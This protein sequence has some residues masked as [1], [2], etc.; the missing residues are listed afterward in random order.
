MVAAK[1]WKL[2]AG[3]LLLAEEEASLKAEVWQLPF[4]RAS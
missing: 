1:T 3:Q 4:Q 2:Q